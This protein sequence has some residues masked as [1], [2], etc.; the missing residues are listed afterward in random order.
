MAVLGGSE[1]VVAVTGEVDLA[2]APELERTLRGVADD[3]AGEVI[4]DLTGCDFLDSQGLGALIAARERLERSSRRLALVLPDPSGL[5]IFQITQ[6][7]EPFVIRS[8]VADGDG[9]D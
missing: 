7:D 3:R 9:H 6:F 4:V 5:K 1:A 8:S 2:T